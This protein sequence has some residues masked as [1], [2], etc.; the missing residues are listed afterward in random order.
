MTTRCLLQVVANYYGNKKQYEP[1]DNQPIQWA[2]GRSEAP[3]D[4][5]QCGFDGSKCPPDGKE[6]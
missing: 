2:G 4:T 3:P 1:V 5:P 6:S